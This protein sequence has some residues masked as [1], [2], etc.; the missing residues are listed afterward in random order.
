[1]DHHCA[2]FD[3]SGMTEILMA[4]N[5]RNLLFS[6]LMYFRTVL[7]SVQKHDS[8]SLSCNSAFVI[9]S[10]WTAKTAAVSSRRETLKALFG[11]AYQLI[12]CWC[13]IWGSQPQFL[14]HNSCKICFAGRVTATGYPKGSYTELTDSPSSMC[15]FLAIH[16]KVKS[17]TF[18]TLLEP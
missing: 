2:G 17:V 10:I 4:T 5:V 14:W 18:H 7:L 6:L 16:V 9:L 12:H 13:K 15:T 3:G 1:M 11:S 8:S